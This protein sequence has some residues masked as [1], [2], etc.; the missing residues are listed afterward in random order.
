MDYNFGKFLMK[1]L[2]LVFLVNTL[3]FLKKKDNIERDN[4][5][6]YS[7]EML[8]AAAAESEQLL[9]ANAHATFSQFSCDAN[10]NLASFQTKYYYLFFFFIIKKLI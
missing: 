9:C 10:N 4:A 6:S 8:V 7:L 5:G 1:S 3:F 2:S